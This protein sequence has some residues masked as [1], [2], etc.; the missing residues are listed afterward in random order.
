V[1]FLRCVK[2]WSGPVAAHKT[3]LTD[4]AYDS[5]QRVLL[6]RWL[7]SYRPSE[8]FD[9]DGQPIGALADA[10]D[11][12]RLCELPS[13]DLAR[14]AVVAPT[15]CTFPAE[16]S[17][18]LR[19]YAEAGDFKV[20]C[21]DELGSNRLGELVA[22]PWAHEVLAEEVLL[23]WLA[24]WTA[25]GRRGIL[26]SYEAFAPLLLTGLI[27]QLK[28]RR[29]VD[30][31]LPS[32]NVLLTS[33]G[34]H[35]SYTHGDPS[36]ITA[37][38]ATGDPAIHVLTPADPRRTAIALDD[39][40]RSTGRVNIVIAGKHTT[41]VHPLETVAEE[42]THGIAMWPH[43]S[44]DGEADL[45]MVIAGDLPATAARQAVT[46]I[47]ELH[48]CAVRVVNVHDLTALASPALDRYVSGHGCLL[49]VTL[50][51]P[52]AI[53]GLL[54][55]RPNRPTEVIG[56]REPPRPMTQAALAAYALLDVAGITRAATKLLGQ[57][58]SAR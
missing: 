24:G 25:S 45:T 42:R 9:A 6:R 31:T 37:L 11:E 28:Q 38:L 14:P 39:A 19:A 50:G 55:G 20:F 56:W 35:N 46:R 36:L 52:A 8:L 30:P 3:P 41:D 16:V 32:I 29:L 4:L 15:E 53:W 48:Q 10:L 23:G 43:L 58:E 49:I 1:I 12:I 40:L 18:V 44:D 26:I 21:P 17:A 22:E 2:G 27:G 54:G 13:P 33:Y 34:W 5:H 57:R 51:H 7:S 47:R